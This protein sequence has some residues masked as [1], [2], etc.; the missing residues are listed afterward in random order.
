MEIKTKICQEQP[1]LVFGHFIKVFYKAT[2]CP[3]RP[4]LSGPKK[5]SSYTGF[6]Q[7]WPSYTGF[8][9]FLFFKIGIHSMQG[10]TVITRH[11]VTRKRSTKKIKAYRKSVWKE[12]RVKRCM[13]NL[14]NSKLK[15]I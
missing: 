8:A 11:G 1:D 3:R 9:V 13:L 4:L 7:K 12:P 15:T 6:T 10:W 2:T 14:I 5:W